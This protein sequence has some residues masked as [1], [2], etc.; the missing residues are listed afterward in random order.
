MSPIP[1]L[2]ILDSIYIFQFFYFL[3]K[4]L[5]LVQEFFDQG[6]QWWLL[7]RGFFYGMKKLARDLNSSKI[8]I[9]GDFSCYPLLPF[10]SPQ[11]GTSNVCKTLIS[12]CWQVSFSNFLEKL[13]DFFIFELKDFIYSGIVK[14]LDWKKSLIVT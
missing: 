8:E 7:W 9:H 1:W 5:I 12:W 4:Y 10:S 11:P 13:T 2:K 14:G 3:S 6:M